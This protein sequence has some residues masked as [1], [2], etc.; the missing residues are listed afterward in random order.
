[1]SF[2]QRVEG[3]EASEDV[4][5]GFFQ[6]LEGQGYDGVQ[7]AKPWMRCEKGRFSPKVCNG[8][9]LKMDGLSK[10]NPLFSGAVFS[11]SMFN[12]KG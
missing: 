8:W 7:M 6:R 10:R 12:F 9:K 5:P 11:G 2:S 1:M 3:Y 4:Y